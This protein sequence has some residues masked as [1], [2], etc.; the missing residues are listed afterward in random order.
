MTIKL[1]CAI[2]FALLTACTRSQPAETETRVS[3]HYERIA[4]CNSFMGNEGRYFVYRVVGI[5]NDD[6][7]DFQ[8]EPSRLRFIDANDVL[9]APLLVVP[10]FSDLHVAAGAE[11]SSEEIYLLQDGSEN[12]TATLTYDAPNTVMEAKPHTQPASQSTCD[13][14]NT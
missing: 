8:F 11:L 7:S 5:K 9:R 1:A 6:S 14:Y 13:E 10:E 4:S 3:I 2:S 12:S